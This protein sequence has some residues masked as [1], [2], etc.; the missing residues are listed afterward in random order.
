M[1]GMNTEP[2]EPT[3][4]QVLQSEAPEIASVPVVVENPVR[5]HQLGAPVWTA[6]H[7]NINNLGES[8]AQAGPVKILGKNP[9]RSRAVISVRSQI[10]YIAPS[11]HRATSDKGFVI[12]S[13]STVELRHTDEVWCIGGAGAASEV[14]VL[15]E[16]WTN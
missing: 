2:M 7:W 12:A 9:R 1:S 5:V 11:A 3:A 8:T 16:M 13:P 10:A 4:E 6:E 15:E 14:T